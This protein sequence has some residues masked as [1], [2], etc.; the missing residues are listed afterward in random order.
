MDRTDVAGFPF[1]VDQEN[2]LRSPRGDLGPGN[3]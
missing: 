1:G 2:L 3:E